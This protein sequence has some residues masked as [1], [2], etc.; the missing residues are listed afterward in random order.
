MTIITNTK[1][2]PEAS[3]ADLLETYN[4]LA[5][6]SIKRF[7]SR[8]A[9][10]VQVTN[11]IMAAEDRAGHAGVPKGTKPVA[12]P[13]APAVKKTVV[14]KPDA[15]TQMA[16]A[17][18]DKIK[19]SPAQLKLGFTKYHRCPLC[20]G[21]PS[22]QTAAGKEGTVAGDERNVCHECNQ[23]YWNASS[24]KAGQLYARRKPGRDASAAIKKT[25]GN[26]EVRAA[27]SMKQRVKVGNVEYRSVREAFKALG[28]PDSKH[29]KFRMELKAAGK[30]KFTYGEDTHA[31]V[32]VAG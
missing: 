28:L 8:A 19:K 32:I 31:F 18:V 3:T 29:V 26:K 21:D 11:A 13:A 10:E 4:A 27:R 5:G 15:I 12:A 9:A 20:G 24:N 1:L 17:V 23:E 25:W 14:A 16:A 6:K 30:G 2:V 7:S 22:A